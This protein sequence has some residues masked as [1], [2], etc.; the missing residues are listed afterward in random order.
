MLDS[1]YIS[2]FNYYKKSIG[3]RSLLVSLVYINILELS[4]FLA[5]ATFFMAFAIQ[6]KM[7][8]MSSLKFWVLFSIISM[9]VIFKN[10]MRYNGKK[11]NV[12][13]AKAQPKKPSIF[14]LWL[15]P[16]GFILIAIV[17]LQAQ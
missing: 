3:K 2:V 12:L 5:L 1:L 10:W 4:I 9:F 17:L 7:I 11:R 15:M 16:L 13:N 8:V 14:L 6:M